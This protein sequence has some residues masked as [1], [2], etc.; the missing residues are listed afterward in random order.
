MS[1]AY[2]VRKPFGSVLRRR[3][4]RGVTGDSLLSVTQ[5][6]G[7]IPQGE[8][9]RRNIASADKSTYWRVYP[10][11]IVYNTM[12]MWQGASSSSEFFGIVSPAYT[13][14][15]PADDVSPKYLAYLLK[16][17]DCVRRF[18]AR[19]QG[20]TSDVWNLRYSEF[21]KI[22]ADFVS[23]EKHRNRITEI[24]STVDEAIEQTEALIAKYQ[25]I[26]AGLMHDLFT[27]GVTP[28]GHLRPTHAQAPNLY[29]E[30]PLGW[31]PKEWSFGFLSEFLCGGPKN[32]YSPQE[33]DEWS[34]IYALGLDCLTSEGF[35]PCHLKAI[36]LGGSQCR[37]ALLHDG[38][39]LLSRSNTPDLV[40][41]CGIYRDVGDPCIYPDLMM[42]IRPN[43]RTSTE[44]LEA[45][46]LSPLMRRR[47]SGAAVGT[48]GSMVKLNSRAVLRLE[49]AM[50]EKDEQACMLKFNRTSR[51]VLAALE[52]DL[53]KLHQQKQGLMHDLLTGR[54][55]VKVGEAEGKG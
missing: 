26:K 33:V 54:V 12:R 11:D 41:L 6:R 45:L 55:R 25:Q 31:I 40:G 5:E 27:C 17:P 19:S 47:I 15:Q 42:R 32:G 36:G 39:L 2:L 8:A 9:G 13:V 24:L 34:G 35:Q 20:I 44:F 18:E 7:V 29:R 28:D 37:K 4:E 23:R 51:E 52:C 50:P 3:Q 21:A 1:E 22:E 53:H 10:G 43:A 49:T 14:C 46:L 48:S 30:S 16:H 38:D